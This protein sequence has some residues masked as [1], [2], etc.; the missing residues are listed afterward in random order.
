MA[1]KPSDVSG[2]LLQH[3]CGHSGLGELPPAEFAILLGVEEM[4]NRDVGR[5]MT[6]SQLPEHCRSACYCALVSSLC[7]PS[8]S[9][10]ADRPAP[11]LY[12]RMS[13]L[14]HGVQ[15]T[16]AAELHPVII[17]SFLCMPAAAY[18]GSCHLCP[19]LCKPQDD[20]WQPDHPP[21]SVH[22]SSAASR[23]GT[24]PNTSGTPP[25]PACKVSRPHARVLWQASWAQRQQLRAGGASGGV[26]G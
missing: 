17:V 7:A 23:M 15:A 6:E 13:Q 21:T 10:S 4:L 2:C 16:D 18:A 20:S 26:G 5:L 1:S 19:C 11:Q 9:R 14:A 25:T 24:A 8:M 12:R 3:C 22:S